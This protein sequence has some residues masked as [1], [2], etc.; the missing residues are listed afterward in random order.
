MQGRIS[1]ILEIVLSTVPTKSLYLS[2][3]KNIYGKKYG[4]FFQ[5]C[6]DELWTISFW[7]Y[8]TT[9]S[10]CMGHH[11]PN[12]IWLILYLFGYKTARVSL[13]LKWPQIFKLMLRNSA[14]KLFPFLNNPNNP[15]CNCSGRENLYLTTKEMW[16][17][18]SWERCGLF[19]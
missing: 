8:L 7:Y 3:C 19:S 2:L 15:C 13:F 18:C 16:F 5:I 11:I 10:I 1:H 12:W 4:Y 6:R 14:F 9:M 17:T